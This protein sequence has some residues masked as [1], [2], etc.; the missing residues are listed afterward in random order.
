MI[1]A[2]AVGVMV[3]VLLALVGAGVHHVEQAGI[4]KC[5]LEAAKDKE[6]AAEAVRQWAASEQTRLDQEDAARKDAQ[7]KFNA[8]LAK[9]RAQRATNT[10]QVT[11][12]V[13][14]DK[15]ISDPRCVMSDSSLLHI[16]ASLAGPNG[17]Q[18]AA[19]SDGTAGPERLPAADANEGRPLRDG[20]PETRRS[21]GPLLGMQAPAGSTGATGQAGRAVVQQ[22]G[23]APSPIKR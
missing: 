15:G 12:D 10:A 8:G 16:N 5:E 18:A 4:D 20:A 19:H 1:Q 22:H 2:I 23:G 9:G 13:A 3:I 11:N 7:A 14:S 21:G 17:V 6:A